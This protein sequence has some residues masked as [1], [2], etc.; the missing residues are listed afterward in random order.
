MVSYSVPWSVPPSVSLLAGHWVSNLVV[1]EVKQTDER[2]VSV[3][4]PS[5]VPEKF[6]RLEV[7]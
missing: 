4:A 2:W 6:L 7:V 5:T 3:R 1:I